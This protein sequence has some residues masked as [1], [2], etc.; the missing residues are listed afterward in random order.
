MRQPTA[1]R[2]V[3]GT[4]LR[5]YREERGYTQQM[6][7]GLLECALSKSLLRNGIIAFDDTGAVTPAGVIIQPGRGHPV[8]G[9]AVPAST[10]SPW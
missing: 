4:A 2:C 6:S 9:L 3:V 8:P 1:S 7:A 10:S 5:R